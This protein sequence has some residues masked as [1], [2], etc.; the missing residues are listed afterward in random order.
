M[1]T[2]KPKALKNPKQSR[3]PNLRKNP[4]C[5]AEKP[6]LVE[7]DHHEG[8]QSDTGECQVQL[9][10]SYLGVFCLKGRAKKTACTG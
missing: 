4:M 7:M 1:P 3:I 10:G 8:Q 9:S 2:A 6:E 5:L